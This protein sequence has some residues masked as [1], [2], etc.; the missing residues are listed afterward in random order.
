VPVD[1]HIQDWPLAYE[2]RLDE[3]PRSA[4]D[5]IVI[6]C[7]ELPDLKT[8]REYGER[9]LYESHTGNSG[10]FYIDRDGRV[11]RFVDPERVAN[12]TRGYNPRS[13]GIELVNLGRYPDW[14]DS[15]QQYMSEAY[16]EAQIHALEAL[17]AELRARY[18]RLRHIAGHEDLDTAEVEASDNPAIQV[19]RK[20]DP[21]PL[22]PWTRVIQTSGL[23][24]E[25]KS[26]R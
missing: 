7:T 9:E 2:E 18:P 8:A 10:H 16:S 13:I 14:Y 1:L 19:P 25:F 17:L 3:R 20:M 22:F 21:G 12:H 23:T 4:I 26:P 11:Y 6:H 15:R 5:L 24:R